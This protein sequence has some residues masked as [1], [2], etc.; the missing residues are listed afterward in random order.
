MGLS[1]TWMYL[2]IF[3]LGE[4]S[5]MEK[6]KHCMISLICGILTDLENK[7]GSWDWGA[8]GKE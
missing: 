7:H 4:V 1:A 8:M 2:E 5:Q 3:I 6:E